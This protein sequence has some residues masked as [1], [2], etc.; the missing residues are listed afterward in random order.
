MILFA[1]VPGDL[2]LVNCIIKQREN[3]GGWESEGEGVGRWGQRLSDIDWLMKV[4]FYYQ[5]GMFL[6]FV[7]WVRVFTLSGPPIHF[8]DDF[9]PLCT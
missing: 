1:I 3:R 9:H 7:E 8:C 4:M 6:C 5:D 2:G